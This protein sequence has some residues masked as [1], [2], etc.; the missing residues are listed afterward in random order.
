MNTECFANKVIL[1][2]GAAGGFGHILAEKLAA[3]GARLVLGDLAADSLETLAN[4]LRGRGADVVAQTCDVTRE[5]DQIALAE[6][7]A[8][9]WGRLDIAVNNAGISAPMKSLTE[10]TEEDMDTNFAVNAKGTFFGMKHQIRRMLEQEGGG[11]ILNVASLAG[12]GGAPKLTAYAA[13][14]HAVV[15]MTKTAALEYARH[16]IRINAICPYYSPTPLV[17]ESNFNERRDMLEKGSPMKRLGEP[18][19]IV[20]AMLMLMAPGNSY[21][22]GQAVAVD[23]GISAR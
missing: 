12:L 1:I 8:A 11:T 14:K 20:E 13:A 18:G 23:G 3:G 17:T 7:A 21:M 9:R 16:H 10:T 15:G 6:T 4:N 5:T 19:E 2:T 22:T